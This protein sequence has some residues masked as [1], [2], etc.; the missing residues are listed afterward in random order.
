M[1]QSL[2]WI[3]TQKDLEAVPLNAETTRRYQFHIKADRTQV[4]RLFSNLKLHR[5]CCQAPFLHHFH[6][7]Q[8]TQGTKVEKSCKKP[9]LYLYTSLPLSEGYGTCWS[10]LSSF[11]VLQ[12]VNWSSRSSLQNRTVKWMQYFHVSPKCTEQNQWSASVEIFWATFTVSI[13]VVSWL[14][15]AVLYA[16]RSIK[17][18]YSR[19]KARLH[20]IW[21]LQY[22]CWCI[23]SQQKNRFR[24]QGSSS[25]FQ[26]KRS[27]L[28]TSYSAQSNNF[29]IFRQ[30]Q[31][32]CTWLQYFPW[33]NW[34]SGAVQGLNHKVGNKYACYNGASNKISSLVVPCW[35]N[36][37]EIFNRYEPHLLS[38]SFGTGLREKKEELEPRLFWNSWSSQCFLTCNA[39][40]H[41]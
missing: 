35:G 7:W 21:H 4:Y 32:N 26:Q 3:W 5:C 18:L 10:C 33:N 12:W 16:K 27:C 23:E 38:D 22:I 9:Y 34:G 37:T 19:N 2:Y 29:L 6:W 30:K 31:R 14:Y 1:R 15:G 8:T 24:S 39:L 25:W 40:S 11:Q 17:P 13:N 20:E 41:L 28:G 36:L